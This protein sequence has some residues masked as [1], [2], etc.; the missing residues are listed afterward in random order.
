MYIVVRALANSGLT[1]Q[2]LEGLASI[3]PGCRSWLKATDD[4]KSQASRKG[5]NGAAVDSIWMLSRECDGRLLDH[6]ATRQMAL[7]L[8]T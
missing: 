7:E 5:F 8:L 3:Q 6:A 2:Q 1:F 4:R